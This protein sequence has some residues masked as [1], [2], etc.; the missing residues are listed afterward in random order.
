VI[1]REFGYDTLADVYD[2][3][4]V[5]DDALADGQRRGLIREKSRLPQRVYSYQ[6]ALT[7]EAA[8]G[9]LLL[10]TRRVLHRRVAE[11]LQ[12]LDPQRANEIGNHFLEAREPALALPYIVESAD[13]AARA[14]STTEAIKY[15]T[16]ALDVLGN[17]DDQTLARRVYEGF[18]GTLTFAQQ[19]PRAVEN[20]HT[21]FHLA[22][23]RDDLPMQVSAL[24]KL[25]FVTDLMQGKFPEAEEHLVDAHSLAEECGDLQGLAELHMTYC[26]LRV[27]FGDF[28]D[29]VDHLSESARIGRE[30]EAEEPRLGGGQ[31][32]SRTRRGAGQPQVAG[33]GSNCANRFLQSE[34]RRP[35]CGIPA[36][37]RGRANG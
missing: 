31:G 11:C 25:A 8:Y 1:G 15:Y 14:Y 7:Q 21:M 28:D 2:V 34:E 19:I 20:Y 32:G 24:N 23:E 16:Q 9:S 27:P 30:L 3:M 18:G 17:L 26:Y 37:R 6:H 36:R 35:G 4:D 5:L 13:R 22:Q 10:S 12:R 29:A 33:R